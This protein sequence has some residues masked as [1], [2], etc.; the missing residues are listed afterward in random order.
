MSAQLFPRE[1]ARTAAAIY[2]A[3]PRAAVE[4]AIARIHMSPS[5]AARNGDEAMLNA[6][7]I[8]DRCIFFGFRVRS[9]TPEE[10]AASESWRHLAHLWWAIGRALS[11]GGRT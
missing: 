4:F 2:A 3:A 8:E 10:R 9:M 11:L 6:F 5:E 7:A 1:R